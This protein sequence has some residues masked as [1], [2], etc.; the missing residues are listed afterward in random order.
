MQNIF[1]L[2]FI[3]ILY[4][5]ELVELPYY[6]FPIAKLNSLEAIMKALGTK[7]ILLNFFKGLIGSHVFLKH[8]IHKMLS[9]NIT[10][11]MKRK[12]H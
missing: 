4:R 8:Y 3:W 11:K 7:K 6:P 10:V 9:K 2:E 5:S 1:L 12:T